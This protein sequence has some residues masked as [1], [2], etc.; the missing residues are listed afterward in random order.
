MDRVDARWIRDSTT[1]AENSY[2]IFW[3]WLQL[4]GLLNVDKVYFYKKIRVLNLHGEKSAI[5]NF[6]PLEL[7]RVPLSMSS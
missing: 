2:F 7:I 1:I 4:S 6:E 5:I 3:H